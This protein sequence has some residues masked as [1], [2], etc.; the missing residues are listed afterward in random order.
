[1]ASSP[2]DSADG[3]LGRS[4]PR[5]CSGDQKA[6]GQ[7]V[8]KTSYCQMHQYITPERSIHSSPRKCLHNSSHMR[9]TRT[10]SNGIRS[11][12]C[13]FISGPNTSQD[14]VSYG[15][16]I[17]VTLQWYASPDHH[18]SIAKSVMVDV[19]TGS[20]SNFSSTNS[21]TS[22]STSTVLSMNLVSSVKRTECQWQTR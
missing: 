20:I 14:I 18:W 9:E 19:V 22:A 5:C 2:D 12:N 4:R 11:D 16:E 3:I 7:F 10:N 21:S 1:M 13:S 6:P 15:M 8:A 17:C